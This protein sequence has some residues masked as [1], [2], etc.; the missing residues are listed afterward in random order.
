VIVFILPIIGLKKKTKCTV[1]ILHDQEA[2]EMPTYSGQV[3]SF[4]RYARFNFVLSG[5]PV[6]LTAYRNLQTIRS[7]VYKDHLFIPFKDAGNGKQTYGGGRYID[8]TLGE[9]HHGHA[10][11][12]L[13]RVYNPWCA[14]SDGYNCPIPLTEN[15]LKLKVKAGEKK[16]AKGH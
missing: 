13:N 6:S 4:I 1:E 10:L 3:K 9:I 7:P 16:F 12:D 8:F 11:L 2:F 14:Y 15:H 5:K